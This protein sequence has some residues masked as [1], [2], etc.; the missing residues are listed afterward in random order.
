MQNLVGVIGLG[1]MGGGMARSLARAGHGIG[2]YDVRP[3]AVQELSDEGATGFGSPRALGAACG[4]IFVAVVNAN[5][6]E[7]VLFGDDGAV[8]AMSPGSVVVLCSTVP[9]DYAKTLGQRLASRNIMLLDAPISGGA[10]KAATGEL[11]VMAAG[12]P[13]AF[14]RCEPVLK[15]VAQKVYRLG[16]APGAGSTVK[17]I[18]QLLAG[19]HIAAAAE[20]MALGIKVGADP[21]V[22]YEVI[23][24][25]AGSSWM[26]Q[27]RVPHIL[28]GD[29][30]PRSAVT[31]FVKDLG[32]VLE[33]GKESHMPLPLTAAAH[34]MY[35]MA[36]AAGHGKEDDAAVIKIFPGLDLPSASPDGPAAKASKVGPG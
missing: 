13:A 4:I 6:A 20:A 10:A 3:T 14:D 9:P 17:M 11:T 26:F 12:A 29:Y 30:A 25:S 23:S 5:Q 36:C 19:V 35:L 31:I 2:V 34:Q 24:N 15:A 32:I 21:K 28:A 8:Q 1:A 7:Q 22:L 16:D 18:N 33:A 27:N